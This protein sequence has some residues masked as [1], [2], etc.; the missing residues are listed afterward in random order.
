MEAA[1]EMLAAGVHLSLAADCI[2]IR[3]IAYF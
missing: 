3:Q 2:I 1:G